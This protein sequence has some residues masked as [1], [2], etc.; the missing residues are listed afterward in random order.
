V[1]LCCWAEANHRSLASFGCL[2]ALDATA[3][4]PGKQ[5]FDTCAL[6]TYTREL[7]FCFVL[8]FFQTSLL[9]PLRSAGELGA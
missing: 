2:N 4:L 1:G 5:L 6:F 8:F 3:C 7:I 9:L